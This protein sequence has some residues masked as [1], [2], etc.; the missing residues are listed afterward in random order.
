VGEANRFGHPAD[1]VIER[2]D[3]DL[4]LR[5]DVDGDVRI[6]TDG[7]RLWVER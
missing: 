4:V 3:G 2:L 6:E 5:T 7:T 1:E